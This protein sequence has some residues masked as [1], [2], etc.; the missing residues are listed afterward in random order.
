MIPQVLR[1]FSFTN[2]CVN[3]PFSFLTSVSYSCGSTPLPKQYY[4]TVIFQGV[5]VSF[6]WLVNSSTR[7]MDS[8][9]VNIF[10]NNHFERKEVGFKM[11]DTAQSCNMW[12]GVAPN[13]NTK[14]T[15][16]KQGVLP[17]NKCQYHLE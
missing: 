9:N 13:L 10:N 2:I 5:L 12:I 3:L 8:R 16:R 1:C 14:V 17:L 11:S 6:S 7:S 15:P 4:Q